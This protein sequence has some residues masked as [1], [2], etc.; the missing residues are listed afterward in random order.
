MELNIVLVE[1]EIPQNTGNIVRTCAAIGA[2]LHLVHPLGF[3]I[4]D[5]Q[6]KR[7]GL[8]YWDKLE[9]EEHTSFEKFL[10]KYKPKENNM[11]FVTTKGK[12]AYSN[13]KYNQFENVFLLF[14]KETK[15]LPEEILQK[16]INN[17]I[18]IP[19]RKELRSLN[20]SN[21]VAVVAYEVLRQKEFENMEKISRHFK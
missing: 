8:D 7:A 11:F 4:S 19:M 16:Y 2:K 5:K 18:R 1:P 9:I 15:G 6:V 3:S 13:I 12:N 14:G 21:S 20:L 10:E 17:T